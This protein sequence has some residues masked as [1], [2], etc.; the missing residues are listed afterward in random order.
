M[1]AF[2]YLGLLF[3]YVLI[4]LVLCL[5]IDNTHRFAGIFD[6]IG[7]FSEVITLL[8]WPFALPVHV[9]RWRRVRR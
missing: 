7:S 2:L 5:L 9:L 8:A 6:R 3:A 4:G 1:T